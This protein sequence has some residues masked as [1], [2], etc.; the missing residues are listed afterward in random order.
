MYLKLQVHFFILGRVYCTLF[1]LILTHANRRGKYQTLALKKLQPCT[2]KKNMEKIFTFLVFAT[3]FSSQIYAQWSA[4]RVSL[5]VGG[6]IEMPHGLD[7]K[8]L[9][10]TAV[11]N[12]FDASSVPFEDGKLVRMDCDNGTSRISLAFSPLGKPSTEI[13]FSI[14]NIDGRIDMV[15]YK[16]PE[17]GRF[18]E[19]SATNEEF[20]LEGVYMHRHQ[21]S[22]T[23][24]FHVGGGMNIGLSHGG[25]ITIKSFYDTDTDTDVPS[26]TEE[27]DLEYNQKNSFNQRLFVQGGMGIR[28]LKR[29]EF[30]IIVR[31]GMGYRASFDGPF[32]FTTLKRSMGLS[33][34]YSL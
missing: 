5:S 25:K 27:I 10:S 21:A 7:H 31:K 22:K 28:F 11:D 3:L 20:A 30:G 26:T 14:L 19:V 23:F 34:S 6:D 18:A 24:S 2:K 8:Y 13:Q 29:L 1:V 15:R 33:L 4:T 32:N 17:D 9:L 12:D 16:L